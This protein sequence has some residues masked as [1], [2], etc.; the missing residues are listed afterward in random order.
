[1]I[2]K[3]IKVMQKNI[4]KVEEEVL[5]KKDQILKQVKKDIE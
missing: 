5:V 3:I 1:M 2:R 4:S